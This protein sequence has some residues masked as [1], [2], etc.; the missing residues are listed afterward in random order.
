MTLTLVGDP[1]SGNIVQHASGL[2]VLRA[3]DYVG[4]AR[5]TLT[6]AADS[7]SVAGTVVVDTQALVVPSTLASAGTGASSFQRFLI[8]SNTLEIPVADLQPYL[9]NDT[10]FDAMVSLKVEGD[11]PSNARYRKT[12]AFFNAT[13]GGA[14]AGIGWGRDTSFLSGVNIQTELYASQFFITA[15]LTFG[16][17]VIS[18]NTNLVLRAWGVTGG[19]MSYSIDLV[20]FMPRGGDLRLRHSLSTYPV[21]DLSQNGGVDVDED[22]DDTDNVIGKFSVGGTNHVTADFGLG[23]LAPTDFQEA[24]DE[25]TCYD[26][27]SDDWTGPDPVPEDPKSWLSFIGAPQYIPETVLVDDP[28]TSIAPTGSLESTGP[29][30][31]MLTDELQGIGGP[32]HSSGFNGWTG[33]NV[34]EL[35]CYLPSGASQPLGSYGAF[36]HAE[37]YVGATEI[38]T[39]LSTTDPRNYRHSLLGLE[40]HTSE[41]TFA[42]NL[43]ATADVSCLIGFQAFSGSAFPAGASFGMLANGYGVWLQLAGGVLT[44]SLAVIETSH[45][46]SPTPFNGTVYEFATPTTLDS[47]Y[48]AGDTWRVKVERRRYRIRAKVWEDG[49]SEP[50]SWTFDEYMPFRWGNS[51][52]TATGFLDYPYDDNW[53][54]DTDHDVPEIEPWYLASQSAIGYLAIPGTNAPEQSVIAEDYKVWIEPAGDTPIDM[55]VAEEDVNGGNH[56]NDVTIPFATIPSHRF[57]EGSLR[58]RHFSQ[59]TQGF[60]LFAWKDGSS[61]PEMQASAL[62]WAW[63]LGKL[64]EFL[65]QIYRRILG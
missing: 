26:I 60:N 15:P 6:T 17:S 58:R 32:G 46:A 34:S 29:Q 61:G 5:G 48:S 28:F 12:H 22:N 8:A 54:G 14:A 42:S 52:S 11:V 7:D 51:G 63:E 13:A 23:P 31:Y 16:W 20:Y 35:I 10:L 56:S 2:V 3:E 1:G 39:G 24:D 59:D 41:T 44:A 62:P 43:G 57:I 64:G 37:L 33:N 21:L 9:S 18:G 19:T 27:S 25:P 65:P 36:P 45:I 40:D 47:S 49:A 53:P 4:G 38:P 50:G 30:G 55:L